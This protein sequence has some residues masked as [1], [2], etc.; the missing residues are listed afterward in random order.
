M[1]TAMHFELTMR[2]LFGEKAYQI[3]GSEA[4][5][6][7]RRE[8]LR[9][10]VRKLLRVVN[11]LDTTL[12]HKQALMAELDA[13]APLLKG[14][15]EPSWDLVYRMLS[16][17]SKLLGFDYVRGEKCHTPVYFQTPG[18]YYTA[19][20]L[21]GGDAMQAY[22]DR[23]DAVSVKRLVVE[24][25]KAKGFDHFKISLVLNTT[26]YEVKQL[27]STPRST[28]RAQKGRARGS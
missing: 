1:D 21:N 17:S 8:W 27:R 18:Q 23:K 22:Y 5:H 6:A 20:I 4:H 24:D 26:E 3:A 10:A 9:K 28:G 16:L 15:K 11:T 14:A 12:R 13:I 7:H 2:L 25:L 19:H